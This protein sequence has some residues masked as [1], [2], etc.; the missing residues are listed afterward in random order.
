MGGAG[1]SIVS[2]PADTGTAVQDER[3]MQE[4]D[5]A[6]KNTEPPDNESKV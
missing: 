3:N 6:G 2:N 1:S 4:Q 5:K